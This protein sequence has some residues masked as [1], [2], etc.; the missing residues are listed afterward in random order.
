MLSISCEV[1]TSWY[2]FIDL[3][4]N[5]WAALQWWTQILVQRAISPQQ[6]KTTPIQLYEANKRKVKI[7]MNPGLFHELAVAASCETV[8]FSTTCRDLWK[9]AL[10]LGPFALSVCK[11]AW[12]W[13]CVKA[14]GFQW[15]QLSDQNMVSSTN[16]AT[17][18]S[19]NM[20]TLEFLLPTSC[21]QSWSKVQQCLRLERRYMPGNLTK[22][23]EVKTGTVYGYSLSV[24][25][26]WRPARLCHMLLVTYWRH[27][28]W[29]LSCHICSSHSH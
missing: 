6:E 19:S 5:W 29:L 7:C 1:S 9:L 11:R 21:P 26:H 23:K 22:S 18:H 20:W 14:G 17:A 4:H 12:A 28:Q 25:P 16:L 15:L 2:S 24:L 13:D 27:K 8:A 10:Y 3:L